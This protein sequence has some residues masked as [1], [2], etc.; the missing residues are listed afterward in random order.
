MGNNYINMEIT[1]NITNENNALVLGINKDSIIKIEKSKFEYVRLYYLFDKK[2][3]HLI[4]N[5]YIS[6]Q[7]LSGTPF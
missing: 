5:F 4:D 2:I 1:I 6:Y 3:H 7:N